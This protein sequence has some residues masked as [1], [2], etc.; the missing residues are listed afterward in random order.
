MLLFTIKVSFLNLRNLLTMKSTIALKMCYS[1]Q[2]LLFVLLYSTILAM[3]IL[4][5]H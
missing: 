4:A 5:V 2:I 3:T 1:S